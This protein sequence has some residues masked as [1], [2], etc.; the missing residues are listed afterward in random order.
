M[1]VSCVAVKEE[2]GGGGGSSGPTHEGCLTA[3]DPVLHQVATFDVQK[4]LSCVRTEFSCRHYLIVG[5]GKQ[6]RLSK[7]K[8]LQT[9]HG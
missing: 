5:N 7:E 6:H 3:Y 8:G 9:N 2:G 1:H 4:L